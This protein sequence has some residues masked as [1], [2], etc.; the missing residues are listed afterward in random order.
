MKSYDGCEA[1]MRLTLGGCEGIGML[2]CELRRGVRP[3]SDVR[4][5]DMRWRFAVEP[6]GELMLRAQLIW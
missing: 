6:G 3:E 5:V 4:I 2:D 1:A